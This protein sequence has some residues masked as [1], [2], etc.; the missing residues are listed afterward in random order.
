MKKIYLVFSHTGS[1]PSHIIRL[2]TRKKYSHISISLDKELK[3]M[4]SFGR[5][6]PYVPFLGGF[7]HENP[8]KGTY[9]RFKNTDSIIY[10]LDVS[11]DVYDI[12]KDTI[13]EINRNKNHYHYNILGFIAVFF[14]FSLQRKKHFTCAEFIRYLFNKSHLDFNLPSVIKPDDFQKI[15]DLNLI[16]TG[17]LNAYH[18]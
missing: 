8:R 1:F 2:Y 14:H 7:V 10:S 13:E 11:D 4:Y 16:Y 5:L 12:M 17:K 3:E 6:N 18:G 9:K 15:N